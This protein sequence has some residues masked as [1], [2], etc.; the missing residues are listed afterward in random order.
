MSSSPAA[1]KAM[2]APLPSRGEEQD[3]LALRVRAPFPA[4]GDSLGRAG[5][6]GLGLVGGELAPEGCRAA[7]GGLPRESTMESHHDLAEKWKRG[8]LNLIRLA[9]FGLIVAA[10][11]TELRM[12]PAERTWHGVVAG[13][14]PYE[15][16]VPT[17]A[18]FRERV[19]APEGGHL[20]GPHVFGVGWTVNAGRFFALVRHQVGAEDG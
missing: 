19:W 17:V 1:V 18:R 10:V 14:V 15:L 3:G 5:R 11:V 2:K 9:R 8:P 20:F 13:F 4:G 16:R 12:P 7:F 6:D